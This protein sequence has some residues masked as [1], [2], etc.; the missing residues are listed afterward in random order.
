MSESEPG[1]Y[2][3]EEVDFRPWSN[4]VEAERQTYKKGMLSF[5]FIKPGFEKYFGEID[6][7]LRARGLEVVYH[8]VVSL[9][10]EAVDTIYGESKDKHFFPV[11]KQYLTSHPVLAI[12]IA[13]MENIDVAQELLSLKT[14][15]DG[16]DGPIRE[17]FQSDPII[18]AEEIQQWQEGRHPAQD[19]VTI[20]LTQRN[21][22]HTSDSAEDAASSI[23]AVFGDTFHAQRIRGSLPSELWELLGDA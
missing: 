16:T 21:V 1:V 11:M 7:M 8:D 18:G 20:K 22:I 19:D 3:R 15:K 23:K 17:K 13:S 12:I 5:A 2:K 6:E 9:S 10:D 14:N 4:A